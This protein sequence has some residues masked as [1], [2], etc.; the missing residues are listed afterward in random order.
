MR[1]AHDLGFHL[2][3]STDNRTHGSHIPAWQMELDGARWLWY[4]YTHD[5]RVARTLYAIDVRS[6]TST[7]EPEGLETGSLSV[8]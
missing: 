5:A 3:V 4:V 7:H 8:V 6:A 2:E 1:L